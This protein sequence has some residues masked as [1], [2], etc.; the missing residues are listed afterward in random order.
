MPSRG[1]GFA[2]AAT[3]PYLRDVARLERAW[4]EA[5]HAAEASPCDTTTLNGIAPAQLPNVGLALHP[6]LRIVR[7][8]FPVVAIWQMNIAGGVPAHIDPG[9][10]GQD[11]LVVR[12][13]V[14]V[15]VRVLP[16]GAAAFIQALADAQ[17]V[18]TATRAALG[19]DP[20]FDLAGVLAGLFNT[21]AIVGWS[22]RDAALHDL[23]GAPE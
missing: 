6:S 21:E 13:A 12:P 5:Y 22:L 3:V 9:T 14:E 16:A 10:G 11:A 18:A 15:E 19:D 8:S 23:S 7:S 4:A 17:T 1:G 2:P 20:N